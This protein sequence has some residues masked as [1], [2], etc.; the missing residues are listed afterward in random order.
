[1][2]AGSGWLGSG[3]VRG[4]RTGH[5]AVAA[6]SG[7]APVGYVRTG[8]SR[9]APSAQARQAYAAMQEELGQARRAHDMQQQRH[10]TQADGL[11]AA[12][13]RRDGELAELRAS[14]GGC[15]L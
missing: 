8:T 14:L 6:V 5:A 7:G 9:C 3:R 1:M 13:G 15:R 2:A 4:G 10:A 11:R 12:L